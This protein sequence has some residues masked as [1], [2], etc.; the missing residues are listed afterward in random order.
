MCGQTVTKVKHKDGPS[1]RA[2]YERL[3]RI[4][5]DGY[6]HI[7]TRHPSIVAKQLYPPDQNVNDKEV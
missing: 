1:V 5:Y 3:G 4:F 7:S 6:L 2:P